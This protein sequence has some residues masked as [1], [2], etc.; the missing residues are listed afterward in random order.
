MKDTGSGVTKAWLG[1]LARPFATWNFGQ[2]D[3]SLRASVFSFV[4]WGY[5]CSRHR[6]F[7]FREDLMK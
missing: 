2:I 1:G 3:N 7:V 4:K 5:R 6:K